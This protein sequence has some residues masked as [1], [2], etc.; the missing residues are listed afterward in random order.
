MILSADTIIPLDV[1]PGVKGKLILL[2]S[3]SGEFYVDTDTQDPKWKPKYVTYLEKRHRDKV[4]P[5]VSISY[6]V[7]L[8][9]T[10]F[11]VCLSKAENLGGWNLGGAPYAEI[12]S[13]Q[14][15]HL[16]TSSNC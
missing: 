15:P 4:E 6:W 9:G 5:P 13:L 8:W 3:P 14:G 10:N 11:G 12:G 1:K 7:I 2:K 16:G